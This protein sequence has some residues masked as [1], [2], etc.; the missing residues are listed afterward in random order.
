M[1]YSITSRLPAVIGRMKLL[2][3]YGD[4]VGFK[5]NRPPSK[6]SAEN[7]TLNPRPKTLNPRP[8]KWPETLHADRN[9][10]LKASS[11]HSK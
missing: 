8:R 11:L 9:R 6:P 5:Y 3:K 7:P 2:H 4:K 1:Y 10:G